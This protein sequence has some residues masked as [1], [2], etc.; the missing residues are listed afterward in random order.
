MQELM[1]FYL[2]TVLWIAP[3]HSLNILRQCLYAFTGAYAISEI[4]HFLQRPKW[5][6]ETLT[7]NLAHLQ[8]APF[9][10]YSPFS[11]ANV[12]HIGCFLWLVFAAL[13]IEALI[14]VKFGWEII[15]IPIPRAAVIGWS[16]VFACVAIWA[17]WK[18]TYPLREWPVIGALFSR[19]KKD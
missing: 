13:I 14:V 12:R 1:G 4:Y 2:K 15:T 10:H 18:F 8:C 3:N 19:S 17:F 11:G 5:V 6:L 9:L 16:I 7:N